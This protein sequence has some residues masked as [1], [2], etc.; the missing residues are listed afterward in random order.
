[1]GGRHSLGW[2]IQ[3]RAAQ[4]VSDRIAIRRQTLA[5]SVESARLH[6]LSGKMTAG[7]SARRCQDQSVFLAIKEDILLRVEE[8][9][10]GT[11]SGFAFPS[12]TTY[13][14]RDAGVDGQRGDLA[15]S[16]VQGLRVKGKL[17]FPEFDEEERE[18]LEDILDYPPKASPDFG[19]RE[20]EPETPK[21]SS[22]APQKPPSGEPESKDRWGGS[23]SDGS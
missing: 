8:I 1:M 7:I 18:R 6:V 5:L 23:N 21:G 4:Q 12:Q 9:I 16:A 14:A 22:T 17:P 11:G 10:I 19:P 13:L 3:A 2:F 20:G 15:A